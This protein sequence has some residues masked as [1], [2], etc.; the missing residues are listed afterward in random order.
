MQVMPFPDRNFMQ[1]AWVVPDLEKAMEH[2]TRRAGIGPFF[3][4]E[5]LSYENA[6]YRGEP[7]S[8]TPFNITAAI[9]QAGDTQ[10]ELI[11]QHDNAPS[12]F[13]DL[14]PEGKTGLHHVA[15]YCEDY[16]AELEAYL[17]QGAEVAFSGLMMGFR[18]CWLDLSSTLG[19]MVELLDANPVADGVFQA[20]RDAAESWDGSDPVRTLG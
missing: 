5:Q 10:I 13:R 2:W 16:D 12:M 9:G 14:V 7:V 8:S 19:F 4:F 15:I 1:L 3:V 17:A 11:C 20:F 6:V 18:T